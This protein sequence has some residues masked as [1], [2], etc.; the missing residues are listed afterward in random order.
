MLYYCF[1]HAPTLL[2]TLYEN[3]IYC[4]SIASAPSFFDL[5]ALCSSNLPAPLMASRPFDVKYRK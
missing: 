5:A 3:N 1:E 4:I 2:L